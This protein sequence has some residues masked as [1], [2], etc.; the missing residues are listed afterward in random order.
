MTDNRYAHSKVY[1]L[2]DDTGYYYFGSTCMPLH[3][4][5]H[6]HKRKS[7]CVCERKIYK[8]FT[9]QRFENNEIKI[10]LVE[11]F[12]L[13]SKEQLI[14]EEN[15]YIQKH[16]DDEYCLNTLHSIFNCEKRKQD[17]DQYNDK[18]YK[19]NSEKLKEYQQQY[20]LNNKDKVLQSKKEYR[21]KN[22]DKISER[23]STKY[24][25]I[26]GSSLTIDH[27]V[28]HEKSKKHILYVETKN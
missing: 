15:N 24:T 20:A 6:N 3:K 28:R 18:Y 16:I 13:Q 1:K 26:C 11:E 27:K 12:N 14:K 25:C 8:V 21:E 9:H 23:K 4:R 10:I 22:K 2:V 19:I 17:M 7:K 5:L